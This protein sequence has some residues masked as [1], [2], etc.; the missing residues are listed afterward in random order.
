MKCAGSLCY[1]HRNELITLS[2]VAYTG[3]Q[4]L[5]LSYTYLIKLLPIALLNRDVPGRDKE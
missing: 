3:T 1:F 2:T 4:R 5:S